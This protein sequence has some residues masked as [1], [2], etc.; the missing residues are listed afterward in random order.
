MVND[1]VNPSWRPIPV[2]DDEWMRLGGD[3][4]DLDH[5]KCP[6]CESLT[7]HGICLNACHLSVGAYRRF[8]SQ[9]RDISTHVF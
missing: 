3:V 9:M 6:E 4:F 7:S 2:D 5:T 8:I 1:P